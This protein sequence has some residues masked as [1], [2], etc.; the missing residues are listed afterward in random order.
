V[1]SREHLTE[2]E[3]ERRL[4][5]VNQAE[6]RVLIIESDSGAAAQVKE[7]LEQFSPTDPVVV[8]SPEAA[9]RIL[10]KER[11]SLILG[12]LSLLELGEGAG[13]V[14]RLRGHGPNVSTVLFFKKPVRSSK[15]IPSIAYALSRRQ[16][17]F[18]IPSGG[19][20]LA[21]LRSLLALS[22]QPDSLS[23][24]C[25]EILKTIGFF[26]GFSSVVLSVHTD[27]PVR[28]ACEGGVDSSVDAQVKISL[29]GVDSSTAIF[30]DFDWEDQLKVAT[31]EIRLPLRT[32]RRTVG[33]II[34]RHPYPLEPDIQLLRFAASLG[35]EI[36]NIVQKAQQRGG[37][38]D[39]S[40]EA[41]VDRFFNDTPVCAFTAAGNGEFL[42]CNPAMAARLG[43]SSPEEVRVR[44]LKSLFLNDHAWNRFYQALRNSAEVRD[45]GVKLR[46]RLGNVLPMSAH[47]RAVTSPAGDIVGIV[48]QISD[49]A[50]EKQLELQ[51]H[52]AL[53]MEGIGR[54][55]GGIAHDF[56][57]LLT[58]IRGHA[59]ILS[60]AVAGNRRLEG[61][62]QAIAEATDQANSLTSQLL[63]FSRKQVLNPRLIELN[64]VIK[65]MGRMLKRIV[66]SRFELVIRLQPGLRP[67][68]VDSGQF[69]QVLMNLTVNA[70][71]A[72]PGGGRIEIETSNV[73]IDAA[74]AKS[75]VPMTVGE[76]VKLSFADTG[77]GMDA[78]ILPRIF[79]PF[80]T[81]KENGTG[82]GLSTVYG[83]VKQSG[84]FI[85]VESTPQ[86]GS[87]FEI[88]LPPG[89]SIQ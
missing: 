38:A 6:L 17:P 85:Y 64:D 43:Y 78:G 46:D 61:H 68:W 8:E 32:G 35:W 34:L 29:G 69:E 65:K 82:L 80:F 56:N 48:G 3:V 41:S 88:Y 15:L 55:A 20:R 33:V 19:N 89:K 11:F 57:N 72:M 26:T 9:L 22:L 39:E 75:H 21:L 18:E 60:L 52:H 27:P 81:T 4:N 84:G 63:A 66:G 70:L 87:T 53:R 23:A 25:A 13:F 62:L 36:L 51:L 71:D 54:L 16:V 5:R 59:D 42:T 1:R 24:T 45:Q 7:I 28:M 10:E 83:I 50:R 2:E 58:I 79:E 31:R 86:E 44:S 30:D 49:N 76:Y 14:E 12:D 73:D 47:V 77:A 37:E 40:K 74:Y 67:V